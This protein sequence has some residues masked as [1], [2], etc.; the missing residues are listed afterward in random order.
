M[1]DKK[2]LW[3]YDEE[4]NA[5]ATACREYFEFTDGQIEENKF[6]ILPSVRKKD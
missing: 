6:H 1:R 2:C 4:D 5:W 3:V